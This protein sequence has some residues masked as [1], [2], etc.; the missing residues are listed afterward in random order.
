MS[1]GTKGSG[2]FF[3]LEIGD[4]LDVFLHDQR[5]RRADH[6]EDKIHLIG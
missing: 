1:S 5:L 2:H 4:R 6:V 3:A